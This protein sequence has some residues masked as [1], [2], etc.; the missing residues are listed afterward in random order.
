MFCSGE[1]DA[2]RAKTD[3][4]EDGAGAMGLS[5]SQVANMMCEMYSSKGKMRCEH[6]SNVFAERVKLFSLFSLEP[7]PA[8]T[9]KSAIISSYEKLGPP[10]QSAEACARVFVETSAGQGASLSLDV[11]AAGRSPGFCGAGMLEEHVK[12]GEEGEG[13]VVLYRVMND[14]VD[15]VSLKADDSFRASL[16]FLFICMSVQKSCA[17]STQL[18]KMW[19]G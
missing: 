18:L 19:I 10:Q 5:A 1:G 8:G 17:H 3:E 4:E 6:L 11:Y 14:V 13:V 12:E 7:L 2:K 15:M 16:F 9:G